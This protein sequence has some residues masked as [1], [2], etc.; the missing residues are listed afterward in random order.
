MR[1]LLF[2]ARRQNAAAITAFQSAR[3]SPTVGYSRIALEL[4]DALE[5]EKRPAEAVPVLQAAL[6]SSFEGSSLYSTHTELH[7]RLARAWEQS[8]RPDSA[9]V[10]YQIVAA[11]L[12][13]ADPELTPMRLDAAGRAMRLLEKK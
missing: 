11:A 10:H 1:G 7:Y 6:R 4:A 3:L 12:A 9:A 5:A 2:K 13:H 8:G